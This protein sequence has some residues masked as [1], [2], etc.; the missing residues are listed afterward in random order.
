MLN[1]A[2]LRRLLSRTSP[3][4]PFPA[5]SR[6]WIAMPVA[7]STTTGLHGPARPPT[8]HR[9]EI[10]RLPPPTPT[11]PINC[12]AKTDA[13]VAPSKHMAVGRWPMADV[14][15][16]P[17]KLLP[18]IFPEDGGTVMLLLLDAASRVPPSTHTTW[19]VDR[20]T[21]AHPYPSC[22]RWHCLFLRTSKVARAHARASYYKFCF[23]VLYIWV[24]IDFRFNFIN[25]I[26]NERWNIYMSTFIGTKTCV[27]DV[28]WFTSKDKSYII[29]SFLG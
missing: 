5:P 17:E 13:G 6:P 29:Q 26:H 18:Q 3:T 8:L 23:E 7:S 20:V 15:L 14:G 21:V 22:H 1:I 16:A 10:S 2:Y 9:Q 12:I 11:P 24:L 4:W 25:I 28:C 19:T 27:C